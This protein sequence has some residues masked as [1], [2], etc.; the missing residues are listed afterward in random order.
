MKLFNITLVIRGMLRHYPMARRSITCLLNK[1][2]KCKKTHEVFII[3]EPLRRLFITDLC[4]VWFKWPVIL[5]GFLTKGS[6]CLCDCPVNHCITA[7]TESASSS[8]VIPSVEI[9]N[10]TVVPNFIGGQQAANKSPPR[11]N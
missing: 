3:T 6:M 11:M 4:Y 10:W 2:K 9:Q 8:S 1:L 7:G 5:K